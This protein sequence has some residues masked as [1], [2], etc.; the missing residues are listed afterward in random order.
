[1]P[2]RGTG[3][4]CLRFPSILLLVDDGGGR[5]RRCQRVRNLMGDRLHR[6]RV[7]EIAHIDVG[8]EGHLSSIAECPGIQR[9]EL[10]TRGA[11]D[12]KVAHILA[13]RCRQRVAEKGRELGVASEH[14]IEV[15]LIDRRTGS[16]HLA[17]G[18]GVALSIQHAVGSDG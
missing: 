6:P 11:A 18:K 5:S 10:R 12:R 2:E 3:S 15:A 9:I 8:T 17:L 16:Q 1:M 4:I 7:T 13:E 14:P